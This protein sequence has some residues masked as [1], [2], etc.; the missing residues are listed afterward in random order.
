MHRAEGEVLYASD[1]ALLWENDCRVLSGLVVS[2]KGTPAMGVQVTA[3]KCIGPYG[4]RHI[5]ATTS[6][7]ISTADGSN[8]RIDLVVVDLNFDAFSVP[9]EVIAGTP[10]AIPNPPQVPA[11]HL[12]LAYVYVGAGVSTIVDANIT[13]CR[14]ILYG[15]HEAYETALF[16]DDFFGKVV[17]EYIWYK[18]VTSGSAVTAI[19]LQ[20]GGSN[21][22]LEIT[23]DNSE[24][25]DDATLSWN[26]IR[27]AYVNLFPV[28]KFYWA[29]MTPSY[30]HVVFGLYR[31]STHCIVFEITEAV[32][33]AWSIQC[34]TKNGG[35]TDQG[36]PSVGSGTGWWEIWINKDDDEIYFI[37][38]GE[39]LHTCTNASAIPSG[40]MQLYVYA[41][42][43]GSGSDQIHVLDYVS[44]K[45]LR[46]EP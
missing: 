39:I 45:Q 8:P 34:D 46:S 1:I 33:G 28:A 20:D 37:K 16:E 41:D 32:G 26:D 5:P 40:K 42:S 21:G 24:A 22:R 31:D 15:H 44:L 38:D 7:T 9:I 36:T 25:G 14:V 12:V 4:P 35:T 3:G 30:M 19:A 11:D 43:N 29:S 17:N 6:K 27:S 18:S 2:E 13:D 10:A 23:V